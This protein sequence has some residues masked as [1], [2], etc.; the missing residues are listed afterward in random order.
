MTN[1]EHK[2]GCFLSPFIYRME[3]G[4]NRRCLHEEVF[5]PHLALVPFK[6]NDDAVRIYNDTPYGLS[7]AV[8]TESYRTMRLF[9]DECEYGMGYVNLPCI[10]AEVHLPFGGVKKSGNGHPSAAGLIE[11]VTHK[12]AWTVNHGTEIKMAQGLSAEVP[13]EK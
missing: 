3:Y 5:G 10:G 1:G 7:M 12:T 2:G 9:R 13:S 11:T 8:I 4:P 6:T